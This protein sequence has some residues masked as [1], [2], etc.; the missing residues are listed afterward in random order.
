[1][2]GFA[3][4]VDLR[5][6]GRADQATA[7]RMA[8]KLVHRGPDGAGA[9]TD[10]HAAMGFRR[11]KIIDL[12]RSDQPLFNEDGSLVLTCNGEIFDY[13]QLRVDLVDRGHRL[14]TAGDVEVLLH[15]YEESG[16][17][18]LERLNGQFGFALYDRN[19]RRLLLARDHFGIVPVFYAWVDD[20]LIFGSE[21]KA[22]LEHP[23]IRPEVDLAGLDQVFSFP[24]LVS[25]RTMFRGIRSLPPGHCLIAGEGGSLV[26]RRYWDLDYP[27]GTH[28]YP[29]VAEAD[30]VEQLAELLD[31]SVR[32][33]LQADVPVGFYLSGGLDSSLIGSLVHGLSPRPVSSF[34]MTFTQREISETT[35]QRSVSRALGSH[36]HELVFDWTE[37]ASRMSRTIYHSECPVKETYDACSLALSSV[38]RDAGVRVVLTGEGADELFGGYVG[39]RLDHAGARTTGDELEEMLEREIR[40]RLWG[41][42]DLFYE[43]RHVAQREVKE[44]LFSRQVR[45]CY[46]DFDCLQTELVDPDRLAGR[47]PLHQRSYLDFKLRLADHL[48]GDHGDR[49]AL[50]SSVEARYPFL[51]LDLVEWAVALPPE[52]KVNERSEKYILKKAASGR[53]PPEVLRRE[54]YGFHAPGSPYLLSQDVEWIQDLLSYDRIRRDGYFDPDTVESLKAIYSQDGFELNLPFET[55][56][57]TIVLTFGLF[58]DCFNL[59]RLG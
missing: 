16:I 20:L 52:L 41:D 28:D 50:A 59:P 14:S 27:P 22:L 9:F 29:N 34:S 57:L 2:C 51:D 30:Y 33:R 10:G 25:P 7:V 40:T 12:E 17:D 11:L 3:G 18:F 44:A 45:E 58:V 6:E 31:R 49:M 23:R 24:G 42:P 26:E 54:K 35:F 46:H 13:R 38:A 39:Y 21:V 48:L 43:T 55:D 47:H 1:M 5:F 15:L 53:I 8:S 32:R 19:R 36:H 4:Y 37:L 56:L